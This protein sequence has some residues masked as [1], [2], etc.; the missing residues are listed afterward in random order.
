MITTYVSVVIY[1]VLQWIG[2]LPCLRSENIRGLST[3]QSIQYQ[4]QLAT[5]YYSCNNYQLTSNDINDNY[6]D[7]VESGFDE[8]GTNACSQY[9]TQLYYCSNKGYLPLNIS[10]SLVNDNICDCCDGSDEYDS[11]TTCQNVC[12][13][14]G[15]ENINRLKQQ[16]NNIEHGIIIKQQL[17]DTNK[18]HI[19]ELQLQLTEYNEKIME[20]QQILDDALEIKN[21]AETIENQEKERLRA[22]ELAEQQRVEEENKLLHNDD[23]IEYIVPATTDDNINDVNNYHTIH[24]VADELNSMDTD[25]T[26]DVDTAAFPYPAEYAAPPSTSDN[27]ENEQQAFPYPAEYAAP[28]TDEKQQTEQVSDTTTQVEQ[29]VEPIPTEPA[30]PTPITSATYKT[31]GMYIIY[32]ACMHIIDDIYYYI[33][34]LYDKYKP[35]QL[36]GV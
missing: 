9:T 26:V 14:L 8:P 34:D 21:M 17:I 5:H 29:S 36:T 11:N 15:S 30:L 2:C 35:K 4:H 10:T 1:L 12:M 28:N 13:E 23:V 6:C 33:H 31:D 22:I 25:N 16:L 20:R 7:C 18:N 3:S 24:N 19:H 32:H 27:S